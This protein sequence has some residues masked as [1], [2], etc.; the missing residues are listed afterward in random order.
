MGLS[1]HA[2]IRIATER[3]VF[4]MPETSIGFFPDVGASFFLP[5]LEGELGTYLA[6]TSGRLKGVEAYW[7]GVATHFIDSSSLGALTARLAE[8]QF[9]DHVGLGERLEVVGRT[10]E[11]FGTGL[12]GGGMG[13][14][15]GEWRRAV[16]RCF[17]FGTVEGICRA[18]E[19]EEGGMREWARETL[20][21]LAEKSPTSLKVALR[22]MRVGKAWSISETFQR[23]NHIAEKFMGH[24]DFVNGVTARLIRKPAEKPVW[25]PAR[26]EEV[27]DGDVDRFFEI[28]GEKRLPLFSEADYNHYPFGYLGLPNENEVRQVVMRGDVRSADVV[29]YF[30]K[31]KYGKPGVVEKVEEILSRKCSADEDGILTWQGSS[32]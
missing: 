18:L 13:V 9:R 31:E 6:L 4:A 15:G 3:T 16:D 7:A 25:Q 14:V 23:E 10:V 26:L 29:D 22:Q 32:R 27:S 5:R 30:V 11:E 21:V 1:V 28:E 20:G 2:P 12:E 19:R 17:G 24:L 8:L